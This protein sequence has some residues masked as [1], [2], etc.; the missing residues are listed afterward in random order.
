MFVSSLEEDFDNYYVRGN[1]VSE[2]N[3]MSVGEKDCGGCSVCVRVGGRGF[4]EI[5]HSEEKT[6]T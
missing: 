6:K 4:E 1:Y 5:F 2:E 3:K